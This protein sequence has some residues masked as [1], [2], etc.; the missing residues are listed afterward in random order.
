MNNQ[1]QENLKQL[2]E[3]F[4]NA[5]Q[6]EQA[7]A[8]FQKAERILSEN[9][10]A[11]PDDML[12]AD[13]KAKI[14][15]KLPAAKAFN[16]R[17]IAYKTATVAAVVV[18]ASAIGIKLLEKDTERPQR[19]YKAAIIPNAIWETDNIAADD[20]LLATLSDEIEQIEADFLSIHFGE[21]QTNG[22]EDLAELE[23]ELYVIDSTFWKG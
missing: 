22:A 8:D 3:K 19:I 23:D 9:S 21:N 17:H 2:L 14:D 13:I 20:S 16:F 4:G 10:P 15:S 6:A 1:K 18:I 11:G 7:I 5:E 12:I